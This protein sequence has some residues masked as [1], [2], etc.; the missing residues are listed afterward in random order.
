MFAALALIVVGVLLLLSNLGF[1]NL[2]QLK[3]LL[4]VWWPAILIVMGIGMFLSRRPR[5]PK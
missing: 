5:G 3:D 2:A 1:V 4:H